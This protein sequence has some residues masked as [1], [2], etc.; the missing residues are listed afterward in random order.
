MVT[1]RGES[2]RH[3]SVELACLLT[4]AHRQVRLLSTSVAFIS[5]KDPRANTDRSRT[6]RTA[7]TSYTHS[8]CANFWSVTRQSENLESQGKNARHFFNDFFESAFLRIMG[9]NA[10]K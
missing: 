3:A 10:R 1:S 4:G 2:N 9:P 7:Q 5:A 8:S 6:R